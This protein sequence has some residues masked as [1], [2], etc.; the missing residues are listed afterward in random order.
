MEAPLT[1]D[2]GLRCEDSAEKH[3]ASHK[4]NEDQWERVGKFLIPEE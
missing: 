1:R 4:A 2:H 3:V